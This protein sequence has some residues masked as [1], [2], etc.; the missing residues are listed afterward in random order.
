[1]SSRLSIS[2]LKTLFY[3]VDYIIYKVEFKLGDR[4]GDRMDKLMHIVSTDFMK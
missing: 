2:S 4:I 1:M 3:I